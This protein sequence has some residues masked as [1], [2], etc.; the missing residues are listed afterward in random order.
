LS[1]F[2]RKKL[3]K[4][5]GMVREAW[6]SIQTRD[7]IM[8]TLKHVERKELLFPTSQSLKFKKLI[9]KLWNRRSS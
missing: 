6:N 8:L 2:E 3:K 5:I 9:H 7:L 1:E 4:K